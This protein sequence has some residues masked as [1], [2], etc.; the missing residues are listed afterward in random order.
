MPCGKKGGLKRAT[1]WI[2]AL[3]MGGVDHDAL[4][5]SSVRQGDYAPVIAGF[6]AAPGLPTVAHIPAPVGS[7]HVVGMPIV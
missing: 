2:V 3:E 5:R 1:M 6:P 7:K 4:D